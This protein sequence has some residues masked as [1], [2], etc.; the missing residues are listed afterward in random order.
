MGLHDLPTFIDHIIETTGQEKITYIGHSQGTTQMFLAASLNP[1]YFSA[2]INLFTALGP[3]TS[4]N[5]IKVPALRALAKEWREVEYLSL[6][7]GVYN[8]LDANWAE[9][10]AA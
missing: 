4:L 10:T 5:N 7:H 6:K 9:E 8:L 1:E 2:K 3:V